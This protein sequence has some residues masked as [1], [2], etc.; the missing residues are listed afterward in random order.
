MKIVYCIA[1]TCHAGGMERVLANKANHWVGRGHEIVIVTTDQR[2]EPPFF[3]LDERIRLLD[4]NINYEENNGKS[5]WNKLSRFPLKRWL[6]RKRLTALLERE[7]P[8]ITISMFGH[9]VSFLPLIQDGSRKILETHF[10]RYKR[11]QYGRKGLW[12]MADRWLSHRES[13]WVRRFDR[14]V[15]LTEED[16][17]DWGNLPNMTVIPN[18]RTSEPSH[19]ADLTHKKVLAIGRYT[20]QKG[21]ERL[22]KAWATISKNFPGWRLEIVGDGE[23]KD[24]LLALAESLGLGDTLSLVPPRKEIGQLYGNASL[25]AL[26]SRYE[27]LP[28]VLLEAQ[29]FGLPIVS[30]RCKCGP[31]DIVT[32]GVDGFLVE[33]GDIKRFADRLASLMEDEDLRMRMGKQALISSERFEEGEV[34]RRWTNLFESLCRR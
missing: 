11:L 4:L 30:F 12:R 2:G 19:P 18:A 16:Q 33:E 24:R 13:E 29:S 32:D 8:D 9:E 26:T 3:P 22:I 1:G 15:T 28:M 27:G 5:F 21:F 6:H 17:H 7:R 20:Y 31:A 14:F 10:S 23:E 25:F 34:M